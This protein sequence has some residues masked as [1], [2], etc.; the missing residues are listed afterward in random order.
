MVAGFGRLG[1]AWWPWPERGEGPGRRTT[2]GDSQESTKERSR[3][4]ELAGLQLCVEGTGGGESGWGPWPGL[5]CKSEELRWS[6][7][8]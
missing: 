8:V 1:W 2:G 5:G 6:A 4:C 7:V 3:R